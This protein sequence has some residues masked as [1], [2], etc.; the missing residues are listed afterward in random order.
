MEWTDG[1][2]VAH[3]SQF[4]ETFK[5]EAVEASDSNVNRRRM[6]GKVRGVPLS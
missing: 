3:S 1:A 4:H 2:Q 6:H 5:M